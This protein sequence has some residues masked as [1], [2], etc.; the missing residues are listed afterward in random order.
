MRREAFLTL[1]CHHSVPPLLFQVVLLKPQESL[2]H[3]R[4]TG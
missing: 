2:P 4:W 3:A 1:A